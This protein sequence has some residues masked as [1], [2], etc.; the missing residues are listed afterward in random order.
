VGLSLV[1]LDLSCKV[2]NLFGES[3]I[4]AQITTIK[5]V[6][7]LENELVFGRAEMGRALERPRVQS[8]ACQYPMSTCIIEHT[9]SS[10]TTAKY[11]KYCMMED[12]N[13]ML[14][15]MLLQYCC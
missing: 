10:D 2:S 3:A 1:T 6:V 13:I 8:F 14:K 5:V 4:L 15:S 7:G 9:Q 12:L 11:G